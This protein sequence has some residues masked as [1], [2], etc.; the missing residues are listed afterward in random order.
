MARLAGEQLL[1]VWER[2][3]HQDPLERALTL[4][5]AADAGGDRSDEERATAPL[6]R[7]DAALL[8]LRIDTFGPHAECFVACPSC[9][10]SLEFALDLSAM[11]LADPDDGAEGGPPALRVDGWEIRFRLPGSRDVAAVAREAEPW[12]ALARRCVVGA[13]HGEAPVDPATLPPALA[14][15]LDAAMARLDP[16]A[17]LSLRAGCAACGAEW[18]GRLDVAAFL[19]REVEVAAD[20]LLWEVDALARVYGWT[21]DAILALSPAR[22]RSYLYRVG[23]L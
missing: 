6:G 18:T 7:R 5:R 3:R 13:V 1:A 15:A 14:H 4:W 16:Q 21:E 12:L 8:T 23:A 19:W 11:L 22:R 10:A 20:R 2:G 9:A 17:D